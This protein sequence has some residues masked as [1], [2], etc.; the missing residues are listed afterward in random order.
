MREFYNSLFGSCLIFSIISCGQTT[1]EGVASAVSSTNDVVNDTTGAVDNTFFG[2]TDSSFGSC[3]N[4]KVFIVGN[5]VTEK[6]CHP[7]CPESKAVIWRLCKDVTEVIFFS[8]FCVN[9]NTSL[10]T[11][12]SIYF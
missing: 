5:A 7:S 8:R 6:G 4:K 2:E 3:D 12:K 11:F 1:E 9:R 10:M